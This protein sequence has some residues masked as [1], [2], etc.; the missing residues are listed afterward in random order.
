[1]TTVVVNDAIVEDGETTVGVSGVVVDTNSDV[2]VV[3]MVENDSIVE[4][5]VV[6]VV[7]GINSDV[8]V[9]VIV[10]NDSIGIVVV[11]GT[12]TDVSVIVILESNSTVEDGMILGEKKVVFGTMSGV[13]IVG[14]GDAIVGVTSV[15]GCT[16]SDVSITVVNIVGDEITTVGDGLS[17]VKVISVVGGNSD[18][19]ITVVGDGISMVG[20]GLSIVK[21]ISVVGGKNSDVSVAL[22]IG[23][24]ITILDTDGV[25]KLGDIIEGE[26]CSLVL[27]IVM[28]ENIGTILD[29]FKA[30]VGVGVTIIIVLV[31]G[32][33]E[34]KSVIFITLLL[35]MA[36]RLVIM[37]PVTSTISV[38]GVSVKI[39]S[40][41]MVTGRVL[42]GSENILGVGAMLSLIVE[43]GI[44]VLTG[45]IVVK[46]TSILVTV[47]CVGALETFKIVL[48]VIKLVKTILVKSGDG[49]KDDNTALV[50]TTLLIGGTVKLNV[51]INGAVVVGVTIS[52]LKT[53]GE[54]DALNNVVGDTKLVVTNVGV[55]GRVKTDSV[56]LSIE[57]L[58][59][60]T[61]LDT[62]G[63]TTLLEITND[64]IVVTIVTGTLVVT[65][66]DILNIKLV[67]MVIMVDVKLGTKD[68]LVGTSDV[69]GRI[70]LGVRVSVISIIV[71]DGVMIS[72]SLIDNVILGTSVVSVAVFVTLNVGL[73]SVEVKMIEV[74]GV[75]GSV[76]LATTLGIV[77]KDTSL[78][79]GVITTGVDVS[80]KLK[81]GMSVN[82]VV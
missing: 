68:V 72:V 10:E 11:F 19:N 70:K 45:C 41:L 77:T 12:I 1:M 73:V 58:L 57:T 29:T 43:T 82:S 67:S 27:A 35:V 55:T 54:L 61:S 37:S 38:D 33:V 69:E 59:T 75:V 21:V 71:V 31:N 49:G 39:T 51:S 16:T 26:T 66:D 50:I 42:D 30:V 53:T 24:K 6:V 34:I 4:E 62:D 15:V 2:S 52:L 56:I 32:G 18:V 65:I 64:G 46:I 20:D 78:I 8:S 7:F 17:T 47:G 81:V 74:N 3:T 48:E 23:D 76:V 63:I 44:T 14:D 25:M 5:R 13:I 22:I 80:T 9:I 60:I 36:T 79:D 28:L 40:L